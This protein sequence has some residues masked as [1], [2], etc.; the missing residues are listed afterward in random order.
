MKTREASSN[1]GDTHFR[2]KITEYAR[3]RLAQEHDVATRAVQRALL[4]TRLRKRHAVVEAIRNPMDFARLFN[5]AEDYIVLIHGAAC[6]DAFDEGVTVIDKQV[7]W[8]VNNKI[9]GA[10]HVFAE[11]LESGYP[12][13]G[14]FSFSEG[15]WWHKCN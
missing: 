15:K 6:A 12:H 2:E 13:P 1:E 14:R 5:P 11:S 10:E 4:G 7:T 9:L 8:L 3:S